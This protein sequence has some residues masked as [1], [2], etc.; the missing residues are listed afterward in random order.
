M[1]RETK[2]NTMDEIVSLI[3]KTHIEILNKCKI[4]TNLNSYINKICRNKIIISIIF[5]NQ[6]SI[7]F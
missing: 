7:S 6:K 3:F 2:K 1:T 5:F 4:D